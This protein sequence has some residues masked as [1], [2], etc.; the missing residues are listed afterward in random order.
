VK[1]LRIGT[2]RPAKGATHPRKRRGLGTG[3][4]N[5]GTAGRGHKGQLARSGGK[6]HR[7]FEGGQMP[8]T[9][10]L[11]KIGFTPIQR[12]EHQVLNLT[13]LASFEKGATVSRATLHAKKLIDRKNRPVKI[14]GMGEL[15]VAL[16][17]QVDAV[18]ESA[19]AKIE[20]AGGT[21]TLPTKMVYRPRHVK[22]ART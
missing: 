11:P 17:V 20:A 3:S 10:R 7:W 6:V 21:V 9:R 1:S 19:K 4:G 2:L 12:V 16:T 13:A 22:K 18:S 14:L 15:T 5:G 8:L